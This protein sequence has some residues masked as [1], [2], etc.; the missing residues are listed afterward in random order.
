MR[1]PLPRAD[2]D[3]PGSGSYRDWPSSSGLAALREGIVASFAAAACAGAGTVDR[4]YLVAGH[5]L[6]LRAAQADVM[7]RLS[8]TFAHLET[9]PG[10]EPD[11]TVHLWDTRSRSVPAP[12]TPDVGD[13]QAPGAFFYAS[14]PRLR[15][16]YQL[17]TSGDARVLAV[18]PEAPTPSLSVL[19][20]AAGEA[21]YWVADARRIP[22]W[23]EAT[24]LRYL[25]DWWL[26]DRGVHQLHAGAVGRPEG[27]VLVVGKSGSG[28]STATLSTIGT[29]LR[30]AGDDY[31]A[32][33]LEPRP[34]VHSLYGS[35]KLMPD[36][37]GR[38]PFLV[39]ALAN[40][41]RLEV[42]KAVVYVHERWPDSVANGFPLLAILAARVV[43]GLVH[44]RIGEASRLEGLAALAPSTV[45][46]MHTRGQDS[47]ARM[48]RLAEAVPSFVL[49]LGSDMP[50]IPR[51]IS[52]LL[53]RLD[54]GA[55]R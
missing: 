8:R 36:H 10:S 29:D 4:Q 53:D 6:R 42:E 44:A 22:Y 23:E 25:L 2:A 32:I 14:D 11:L 18:Y 9:A 46:Q 34:W 38:L 47:L 31:V 15:A 49:E 27:G 24:P 39:D 48:R 30:Y 12:P 5:R 33:T 50:S 19:D 28:K 51:A 35:G 16:G 52:G 55:V 43:P 17:G 37:V 13:E 3:R 7:G 40:A 20:D 41:E 54:A 45:F 26:R 1:S 21:W